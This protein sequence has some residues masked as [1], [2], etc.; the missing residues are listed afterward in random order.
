MATKA[1]QLATKTLAQSLTPGETLQFTT[2]AASGIIGNLEAGDLDF[3]MQLTLAD[4]TTSLSIPDGSI[5]GNSLGSSD[6]AIIS[7]S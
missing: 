3:G 5:F 2:P 7:V 4:T 6:T 1:V